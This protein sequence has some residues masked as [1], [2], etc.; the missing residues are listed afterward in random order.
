MNTDPVA[1]AF[2]AAM[3]LCE[4]FELRDEM[5]FDDIPGWDSLAH[6]RLI[7]ELETNLGVSLNMEDV[8]MIDSVGAARQAAAKAKP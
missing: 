4:T 2:R 5:G 6:M 7:V 3:R 8:A 1:A